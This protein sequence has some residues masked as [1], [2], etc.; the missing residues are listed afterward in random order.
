MKILLVDDTRTERVIMA[1]RLKKMGHEIVI[2]ENGKQAVELYFEQ[3]PDLVLL[4]VMM[5]IMDGFEA[6]RQMRRI[7]DDWV[8]IIFLSARTDSENI[9]QGIEAG[10]DDYLV[11]PVDS[12]VLSAKMKAMHRIAAVRSRLVETTQELEKVNRELQRLAN[13]DGLTGLSNRR[14]MQRFLEMEVK[15]CSRNRLPLSVIMADLDHFK[16]YN[17]VFGH[18]AGDDSLRAV[19]ETLALHARRPTDLVARYGGEEFCVVLSETPHPGAVGIAEELRSSVE[20]LAIPHCETLDPPLVT[21]SAGVVTLVP[22]PATSVE[23]LLGY[24]DTALYQ[25]KQ[26]GRNRVCVHAPGQTLPAGSTPQIPTP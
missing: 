10:G 7:V 1:A 23:S 24:A 9:A 17:D 13:L 20:A 15:R 19:A 3:R 5:P 4:D 21:L 25:A 6:A 26:A 2:G 11:K 18:L 14:T 16:I 22:G 8:P 12:V